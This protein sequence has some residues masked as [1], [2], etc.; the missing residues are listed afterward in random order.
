MI[1]SF[2]RILKRLREERHLSQRQLAAK[3][4]V[5]P[6]MVG[7]Y[8]SGD[9]MPSFE[10]L[11]RIR[12]ILGVSTDCLL[13]VEKDGLKNVSVAGLTIEQVRAISEIIEQFRL[14]NDKANPM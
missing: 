14:A 8:E 1:V 4:G 2:S 3:I 13:G 9:R 6:S 10:T 5:S 7:L 12:Q 11:L